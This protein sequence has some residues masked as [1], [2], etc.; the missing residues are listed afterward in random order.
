MA[1]SLPTTATHEAAS[2][3]ESMARWARLHLSRQTA[4]AAWMARTSWET[5]S[6]TSNAIFFSRRARPLQLSAL[7]AA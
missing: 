4:T 7:L 5:A 1:A 6:S 2:G 3:E